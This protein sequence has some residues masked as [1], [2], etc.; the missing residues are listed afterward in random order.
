MSMN[1]AGYQSKRSSPLKT[2]DK[3]IKKTF[4][5][6]RDRQNQ[7][8]AALHGLIPWL[9]NLN[10]QHCSKKKHKLPYS[11]ESPVLLECDLDTI[12]TVSGSRPP[13]PTSG[14]RHFRKPSSCTN[15]YKNQKN[16]HIQNIIIFFSDKF[17]KRNNLPLLSRKCSTHSTVPKD[18]S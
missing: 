13:L 10:I 7:S 5:I 12:N 4:R 9:A 3:P 11:D 2:L 18:K 8:S 15:N 1:V 14:R 17:S 6:H 16:T